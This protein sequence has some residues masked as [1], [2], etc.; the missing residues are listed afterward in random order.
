MI[1]SIP[2]SRIRSLAIGLAEI[3]GFALPNGAPLLSPFSLAECVFYQYQIE[4][5]V[6]TRRGS[7]WCT[8]KRGHSS[9]SFFVEDET[10]RILVDPRGAELHLELDNRQYTG[11]ISDMDMDITLSRLG[12][13]SRNLLGFSKELRCSEKYVVEQDPVYVMGNAVINPE[14]TPAQVDAQA[15][16]MTKGRSGYFIVSDKSEKE[17]LS[18]FGW[19]VYLGLIMGPAL[20]VLCLA[21]IFR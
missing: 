11:G 8:V 9:N 5:K 1:Q 12:V 6:H 16:M 14:K 3:Q 10:D 15:L 19:N 4:E 7:R 2:T 18:E 13:G 17:L 21:Y 20:T